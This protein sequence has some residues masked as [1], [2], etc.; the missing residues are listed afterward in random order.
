MHML[1]PGLSGQQ[2]SHPADE[3]AGQWCLH[4]GGAGILRVRVPSALSRSL[5]LA[6]C[7]RI[8]SNCIAQFAF[9]LHADSSAHLEAPVPSGPSPPVT[10]TPSCTR[11]LIDR[12]GAER[13][14]SYSSS[15]LKYYPPV[16]RQ[17][18]RTGH[19]ERVLIRRGFH[20]DADAP[21]GRGN[22]HRSCPWIVDLRLL[23]SLRNGNA[24]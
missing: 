16:S 4:S 20:L 21:C 24:G 5:G 18:P 8:A 11:P 12:S 15:V 14:S 13:A 2:H 3:W 22:N 1:M 7:A 6:L 23:D 9:V 10:M 19:R 17:G